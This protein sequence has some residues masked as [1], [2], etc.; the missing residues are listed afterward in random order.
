MRAS[1]SSGALTKHWRMCLVSSVTKTG[2]TRESVWKQLL[3]LL[4]RR[5]PKID[6]LGRFAPVNPRTLLFAVYSYERTAFTVSVVHT[7]FFFLR[8]F[9]KNEVNSFEKI[10][11]Y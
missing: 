3:A 4:H 7:F 5:G 10:L 1:E 9:A 8:S 11:M 2:T 6:W